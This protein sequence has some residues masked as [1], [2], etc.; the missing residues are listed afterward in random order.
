MFWL[1]I[2]LK[3]E[4]MLLSLHVKNFAI[5]DEIEVFFKDHLNILTGETGAGKSIIIGSIN[6]A[7]GGKVSKDIIRQNSEY[8]LVELVFQSNQINVIEKLK[9]YDL[10]YEEDVI[11]ISRKIMA[12]GRTISKI[13]GENVTTNAVKD[14]ASLLLDIHGQHEHQSLLYKHNHL[15]FVDYFAKDEL[16]HLKADLQNEYATYMKLKEEYDS[17]EMDEDKRLRELS[18]LEYEMNEIETAKLKA[19]EDIELES[20][21]KRLSNANAIADGL[22]NAYNFTGEGAESAADFIS[23]AVKSLTKISEYDKKVTDYLNQIIEIEN[24]L[25]DFNRDVSDY[26]NDFEDYG[27]EFIAVEKRLDLINHLKS[28]YGNTIDEVLSY[29]ESLKQK[30]EK[31]ED[32]EEYMYKLKK[33]MS[34]KAEEIHILCN[35]ISEIRQRKAKELTEKMKQALIDLNFLDVQFEMEF[36]KLK[37]FTANGYDDAEFIIS[38]NPGEPLRPLSKVASGGELSRVMLA[39]KSVLAEKDVIGTLIFDEIDVGVSGR[40]AQKVSEK[41]TVIAKNHQILCITHLPQIAAMS[42]Q[43]YVI[44]KVTNGVTTTTSIRELDEKDSVDELARI[45]GGAVITE[46]VTNNAK[47]MKELARNIKHN[48]YK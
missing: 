45:L 24:L 26:M 48:T 15:E 32:Y 14:I 34:L 36:E 4:S 30:K 8:A 43:H 27:D 3:E 40:T 11:L 39:L 10:P 46:N 16:V 7:L 31:Y 25:N 5:I 1:T 38:T 37:Y 2:I 20:E 23:R 18:F 21:Y 19:K 41:L 12:N 6:V 35:Q 29:Y 28:K 44:E 22:T 17:S 42:D 33:K 47:E 13:N 9:E